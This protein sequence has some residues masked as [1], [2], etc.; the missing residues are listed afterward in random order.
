LSDDTDGLLLVFVTTTVEDS[1]GL[2]V[3]VVVVVVVVSSSVVVSVVVRRVVELTVVVDFLVKSATQKNTMYC[4]PKS[5]LIC[6]IKK[7]H[8]LN[9]YSYLFT[10]FTYGYK[11]QKKPLRVTLWLE[12]TKITVCFIIIFKSRL[13]V[14][15]RTLD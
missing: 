3:V 14:V 1:T 10:Y 2:V 8:F 7:K 13:H 12:T 4:R 9:K 11:F 15:R 5:S 6:K